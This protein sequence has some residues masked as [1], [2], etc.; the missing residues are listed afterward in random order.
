MTGGG[1]FPES[2]YD[3]I[4]EAFQEGF[5]KSNSKRI[6]ILIGDAPSLGPTASTYSE[7][8][9]IQLAKSEKINIDIN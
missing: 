7:K 5:W 1:D 9:I 2:V 6:V 3:G 4:H 8:D